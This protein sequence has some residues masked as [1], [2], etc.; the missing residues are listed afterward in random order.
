MKKKIVVV[1]LIALTLVVGCGKKVEKEQDKGNLNKETSKYGIAKKMIIDG[2]EQEA[3]LIALTEDNKLYAYGD[4]MIDDILDKPKEIAS[5]VK[6][7]FAN[8][9]VILYTDFDDNLYALSRMPSI[10]EDSHN[11][12]KLASNVDKFAFCGF[13]GI[14]VL[15]K[16]KNYY[17][18]V[19]NLGSKYCGFDDGYSELTKI[20]FGDNMISD[21]NGDSNFST[22]LLS[23][24]DLY[25]AHSG[26]IYDGKPGSY[27]KILS[28]VKAIK[29]QYA[30]TTNNEIY[31]INDSGSNGFVD[32]VTSDGKNIYDNYYQTNDGKFHYIDYYNKPKVYDIERND[33]KEML[34]HNTDFTKLIY[35]NNKNQLVLYDEIETRELDFSPSS[36]KEAYDFIK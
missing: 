9:L 17:L 22:L 36:M 21:L 2:S 12:T 34:Y 31:Y 32:K 13:D 15:D 26:P 18:Q 11:F 29:N 23:N 35:L 10:G 7:F 33:V 27:E 3:I 19:T 14:M 28:N 6:D 30:I 25:E 8:Q 5:N 16:D 4:V 1:L 24:G 20:N